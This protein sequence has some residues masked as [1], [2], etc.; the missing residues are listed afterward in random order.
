MKFFRPIYICVF[1]ALFSS[2][3]QADIV[4]I[5]WAAGYSQGLSNVNNG[6]EATGPPDGVVANFTAGNTTDPPNFPPAIG[7]YA[8]FGGAGNSDVDSAS[9]ATLLNTSE[10]MVL[11][12]DVIAF[13]LNAPTE[14]FFEESLFSFAAEFNTW[15]ASHP[16]G[17]GLSTGIIAAGGGTLASY[18]SFW[19][20]TSS[21]PGSF[22]F[23]LIDVG[24]AGIV[25][26]SAPD[27]EVTVSSPG[28]PLGTHSIDL[29]AF[30]RMSPSPIPEPSN[31]FAWGMLSI[32]AIRSG[33]RRNRSWR[34]SSKPGECLRNS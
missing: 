18:N 23:L 32:V 8:P 24:A 25:D 15:Q 10:A 27:I 20:L 4:R 7:V 21:G 12:A 26:L 29:D 34:H 1:V 14:L 5:E 28:T 31:L 13:E 33:R 9:L 11:A 16:S 3:A 2:M 6:D 19:G 30:G 17:A 22:G